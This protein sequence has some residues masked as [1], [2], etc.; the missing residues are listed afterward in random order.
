MPLE[1]EGHF[2]SPLK[3]IKVWRLAGHEQNDQGGIT[4]AY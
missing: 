1:D 4:N 3:I 2:S